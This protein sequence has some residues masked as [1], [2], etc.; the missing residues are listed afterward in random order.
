MN[1]AN[2][3]TPSDRRSEAR[4]EPD[5]AARRDPLPAAL[6]ARMLLLSADMGVTAT[7]S[8]LRDLQARNYRGDVVLLHVCRNPAELNQASAL[9]RAADSYPELSLLVHSEDRAGP[10]CAEALALAVPDVNERATWLC[11]TNDLIDLVQAY[12]RSQGLTTPLHIGCCLAA[13]TP[14]APRKTVTA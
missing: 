5:Q 2:P 11:G 9:Q 1:A 7:L 13:P 14:T 4:V 10:F 6:P 12:W 3:L 8:M